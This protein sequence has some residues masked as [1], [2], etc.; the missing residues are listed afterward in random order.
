MDTPSVLALPYVAVYRLAGQPSYLVMIMLALALGSVVTLWLAPRFGIARDEIGVVVAFGLIAA[1]V[2]AHVFDVIAYQWH[3]V[4]ET[5][6]LWWHVTTGVSLFGALF[7]IAVATL[8]VCKWRGFDLPRYAD[9]VAVGCVIAMTIGRIGCALVHDHPGVATTSFVGVD[10]PRHAYWGELEGP[11]RAHDVG[12]DELL[13]MI[14]IA[15][16]A[17][18][19]LQRRLRA[20]MTAAIVAI[21]YAVARF[22]LDFLRLPSLEPARAGLT[23]G[24][25]SAIAMVVIAAFAITRLRVRTA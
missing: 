14:P 17:F 13:V 2:G 18:F 12:L 10:V 11:V 1:I 23:I 7:G 4:A 24:Q 25:W 20:G 3:E 15:I 9:V 22:A 5:P 21:V 8:V 16:L 19:L 6:S